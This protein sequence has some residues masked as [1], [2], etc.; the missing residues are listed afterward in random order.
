M[1]VFLVIF[2]RHSHKTL[3]NRYRE[4]IEFSSLYCTRL[5]QHESKVTSATKNLQLL[6][7]TAIC[8]RGVDLMPWPASS[9]ESQKC[10][11][12]QM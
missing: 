9:R 2:V 12:L 6:V 8:H 5:R 10:S 11:L 1:V 4:T 3:P 7:F